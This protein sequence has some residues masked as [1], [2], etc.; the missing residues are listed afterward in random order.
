MSNSKSNKTPIR[1]PG[2]LPRTLAAKLTRIGNEIGKI[3]KSGY[4]A[5]QKFKFIEYSVIA[6]RIRSLFDEY[7]V[8]INP[9]VVDY[10]AE[11]ITSRSGKAGYH[12]LLYMMFEVINADDPKDSYT[13]EWVSESIDY[14]DKGVNKA[15][16]SGTKYF[17][18]RLFN[19]SERDDED[20]DSETPEEI[21]AAPAA[22]TSQQL[23]FEALRERCKT[24]KTEAEVDDAFHKTMDAYPSLTP[25]QLEA[26]SKIFNE[27]KSAILNEVTPNTN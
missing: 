21:Q 26:I 20:S 27:R 2:E 4:N 13:S 24:L 3:D 15:I 23:N 11:T 16:T 5:E 25:R 7:G 10:K 19:I 9:S 22:P 12:Y 18:M 1:E 14:G 17:L 6:S 8:L